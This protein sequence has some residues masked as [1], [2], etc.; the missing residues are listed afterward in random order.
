MKS[1]TNKAVETLLK[2]RVSAVFIYMYAYFY[3]GVLINNIV[4]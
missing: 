2:E 4:M 3:S 1:D